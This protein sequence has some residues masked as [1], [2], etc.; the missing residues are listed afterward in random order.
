MS[1]MRNLMNRLVNTVMIIGTAI[2]FLG[3]GSLGEEEPTRI[4]EPSDDF[5]ATVIDQ[6]DISSDLRLFSLDGQTFLS[7]KQGGATVSIPFKNI[8]EIE[9][10]TKD[11]DLFAVAVL[12]EGP[13]VELKVDKDRVFYGRLPYGV[14]SIKSE[15]VRKI[16]ITG[17]THQER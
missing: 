12:R 16:I 5:S 10:Y 6:R 13:Q 17:L 4:P 15:D 14:F 7:G 9:F 1:R 2:V 8:R 11:G 3:M